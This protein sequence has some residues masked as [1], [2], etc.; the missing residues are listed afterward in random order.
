MNM[1][2]L[3][4]VYQMGSLSDG[5]PPLKLVNAGQVNHF[6]K[7][8]R[9]LSRMRRVMAFVKQHGLEHGVWK[10]RNAQNYWNGMTVTKLWNG[11]WKDLG[12]YLVTETALANGTGMS[13][14]KSHTGSL[15]W[16]IC[17]D[18]LRRKGVLRP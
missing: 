9:S 6:D 11:I 7:E 1:I 18:K 10:P 15:A 2:Q 4:T 16:R 5:V 14:H 3:I 8:G 13:L 17:H 12:P